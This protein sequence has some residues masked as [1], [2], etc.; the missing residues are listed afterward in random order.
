[1]SRD[2]L[3]GNAFLLAMDFPRFPKGEERVGLRREKGKVEIFW[4][5]N[6]YFFTVFML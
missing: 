5:K 4:L 1:M 3:L 2:N 6:T